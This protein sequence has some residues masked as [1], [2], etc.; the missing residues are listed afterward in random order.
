MRTLRIRE[1]GVAGEHIAVCRHCR[2]AVGSLGIPSLKRILELDKTQKCCKAPMYFHQITGS[3]SYDFH[4]VKV[5]LSTGEI[6]RIRYPKKNPSTSVS[7]QNTAQEE[8][9]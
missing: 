7:K 4:P 9:P 2:N 5:T 6:V 3:A 1:N 8:S